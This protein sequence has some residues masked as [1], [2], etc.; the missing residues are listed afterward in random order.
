MS[1]SDYSEELLLDAL[2]A[3]MPFFVALSTADPGEAGAGIAEPVSDGYAR[4]ESSDFVRTNSTIA[5]EATI[6]FADASG[7]GWGHITHFALFDAVTDGN[8][9][10]SGELTVHQD[11]AGGKTVQI[12]VG[13]IE[14]TL[15]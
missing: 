14:I 7:D 3:K 11:V 12:E 8:F 5:N 2:L 9:L 6:T 10:G 1:L 13:D 4:K 15:T